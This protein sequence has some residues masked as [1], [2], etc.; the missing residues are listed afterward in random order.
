MPLAEFEQAHPKA[1][2]NRDKTTRDILCIDDITYAGT[3]ARELAMFFDQHLYSISLSFDQM[4][5]S[6]VF[7]GLKEKYGQPTV[8]HIEGDTTYIWRNGISSIMF[9]T[10]DKP[11]STHVDFTLDELLKKSLAEQER[12][13]AAA[14]KSDM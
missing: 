11:S 6:Q 2:L 13:R 12:V 7:T 10:N 14:R 4:D 8:D 5:S 1:C 9:S 3:Q